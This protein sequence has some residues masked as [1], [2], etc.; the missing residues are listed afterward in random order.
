MAVKYSTGSTY[1]I[2]QTYG[3]TLTVSAAS[4]AAECVLTLTD[5]STIAV[6]DIVEFTN[7]GWERAAGRIFRVKAKSTNDITLEGFDTSNATNFPAA[8]GAGTLREI[9]AWS[10]ISQVTGVTPQ[11]P[12]NEFEDISTVANAIITEVPIAQRLGGV[13][14]EV[15]Y[16]AQAGFLAYLRS[17]AN[18]IAQT[19]LRIVL[20]D[21]SR[22]L[23][24]GYWT[25][26]E[27]PNIPTRGAIKNS[28]SFRHSVIPTAY[29]S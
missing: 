16:D 24:N 11:P 9:T 22:F 14:L 28:I 15:L 1:S 19:A 21:G 6:N 12:S 4:N 17:A 27:V 20:A 5:A 7:S 18:N 2:A 29:L 8:G 10:T 25:Y 26:S 3:A 23:C 13:D